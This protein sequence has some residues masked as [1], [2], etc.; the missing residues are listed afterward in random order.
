ML[1]EPHIAP[2]TNFVAA[3][4]EA[5]PDREFPDFDPL[6][7]GANADLLF[8][9]EKPGPMNAA[10]GRGSGFISRNNDDPTAAAVFAFMKQANIPR[11]RTALWNIIPGWNGTMQVKTA[12]IVTG[13]DALKSLLPLLPRLQTII[14]VGRKAQRAEPLLEKL[15]L[16]VL[17]SAHPSPQVRAS[18]PETWREIPAIWA[19]AI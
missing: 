19:Q 16:R 18:Q 15:G 3:L 12:E 13:M 1:H 7:G 11:E 2:L 14:L 8:L 9:L 17:K 6:D 4:R 5:Q 10:S